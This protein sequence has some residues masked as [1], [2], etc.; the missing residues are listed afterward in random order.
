MQ[1]EASRAELSLLLDHVESREGQAVADP[2]YG[3]D[4]HFDIAWADVEEGA[5]GLARRIAERQ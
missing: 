1:P 3:D 2:Y 4:E 5:R